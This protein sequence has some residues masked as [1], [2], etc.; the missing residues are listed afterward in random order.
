M[1]NHREPWLDYKGALVRAKESEALRELENQRL[2]FWWAIFWLLLLGPLGAHKFYIGQRKAGW[3]LIA[4]SV[5]LLILLIYFSVAFSGKFETHA[6]RALQVYW[7]ATILL[8]TRSLKID[9][10]KNNKEIKIND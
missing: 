10:E 2:S 5:V 7:V 6:I 9:V 1:A 4:I 8:S 3:C